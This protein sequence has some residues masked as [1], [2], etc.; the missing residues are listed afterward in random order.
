MEAGRLFFHDRPD[1]HAVA[2]F[3]ER[4]CDIRRA[5]SD[6]GGDDAHAVED[7]IARA[8]RGV[9]NLVGIVDGEKIAAE[10][11][12]RE[13]R[14]LDDDGMRVGLR[15]KRDGHVHAVVEVAGGVVN[16]RVKVERA[17][18]GVDLRRYVGE[19]GEIVL[20]DLLLKFQRD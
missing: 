3:Q 16:G 6:T 18:R 15:G 9:D 11:I 10:L 5:G 4:T 20:R 8:H 2:H 19:T 13:S 12:R 14:I 1:G 17:G 7:D